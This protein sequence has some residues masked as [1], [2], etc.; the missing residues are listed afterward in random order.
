[1]ALRQ[2]TAPEGMIYTDGDKLW[3]QKIYLAAT[4][5]EDNYKLVPIS[6]YESYREAV[7]QP[8]DKFKEEPI[9][10]AIDGSLSDLT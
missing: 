6:E 5:S 4:D 10:D 8:L 3:S 9:L 7:R 1:M 2:I